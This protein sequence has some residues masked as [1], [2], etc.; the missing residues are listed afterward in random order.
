MGSDHP[1]EDAENGWGAEAKMAFRGVVYMYVKSNM[2][3]RLGGQ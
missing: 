3:A 1:Y 2:R